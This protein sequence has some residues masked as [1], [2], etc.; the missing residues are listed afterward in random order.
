MEAS[1]VRAGQLCAVKTINDKTLH[2][3]GLDMTTVKKEVA[4]L[5]RLSHPYIV[6]LITFMSETRHFTD[7]DGEDCEVLEHH[8][9]MELAE[10]GSL[11]AVIKAKPGPEAAQV[12]AIPNTV[13]LV[14]K[15]SS[16]VWL[17]T[18]SS[19]LLVHDV[20]RS[21]ISLKSAAQ[22]PSNAPTQARI[23]SLSRLKPLVLAIGRCS[24]WS[25]S[26]GPFP[27]FTRAA[28]TT[29]TSRLS[30]RS[31]RFFELPT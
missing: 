2:E 19:Y 24:G 14:L 16:G 20:L 15:V 27:T 8:L 9:V 11:A 22:F 4:V 1:G 13:P 10:G 21:T 25:R 18:G 29:A 30:F 6:R 31:F 23:G 5:T 12:V 28:C 26:R 17:Q 7:E 3:H